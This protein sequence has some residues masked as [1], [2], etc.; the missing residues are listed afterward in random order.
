MVGRASLARLL[1]GPCIP[2][3]MR[4]HPLVSSAGCDAGGN[5]AEDGAGEDGAHW[6]VLFCFVAPLLAGGKTDC[7][8]FLCMVETFFLG[9]L[10]HETPCRLARQ[11]AHSLLGGLGSDITS[12]SLTTYVTA[13]TAKDARLDARG[14]RVACLH[15]IVFLGGLS[16]WRPVFS[17]GCNT[18]ADMHISL[19]IPIFLDQK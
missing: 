5:L 9:S 10:G 12:C 3:P 17:R 4:A 16:S 15:T 7:N 8:T 1:P 13:N 14:A 19:Y 18:W 2:Y 11:L 6:I